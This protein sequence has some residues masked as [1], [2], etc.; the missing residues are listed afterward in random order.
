ML[1]LSFEVIEEA[2]TLHVRTLSGQSLA[3][4]SGYIRMSMSYFNHSRNFSALNS[5]FATG[6][7]KIKIDSVHR[8]I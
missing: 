6:F 1:C 5:K 8:I 2:M 4:R 3:Q 7:G